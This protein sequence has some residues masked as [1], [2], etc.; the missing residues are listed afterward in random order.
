MI[1]ERKARRWAMALTLLS[2]AGCKNK[3][4]TP[5]APPNEPLASASVNASASGAPTVTRPWVEPLPG[6]VGSVLK[7][8]APPVF[9]IPLEPRVAILPGQGLGPIRFGAT[10]QT[11][12]RLLNAKC[13]EATETLCRMWGHAMDF[14]FDAGG[15]S[16]M[17][18]HGEERK[19]SD[20]PG[21]TY[22]FF[23]GAFPE[24]AAL[25]MYPKFLIEELGEPMRVEKVDAA[26]AERFPTV[27][28]HH[29]EHM[30]LEYDRL[31]NGN[32][33]LAGV[34]LKRPS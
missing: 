32:V 10:R 19:F 3:S 26:A 7:G 31:K 11:V 30:V 22:G 9:R 25:G 21:D 1:V 23:N 15:V 27:E 13:S 8:V 16:E 12:E 24:G 6:G 34:V 33:V 17:R 4:D 29:Y 14:V 5:A 20:K 18:V 28:R 2:A